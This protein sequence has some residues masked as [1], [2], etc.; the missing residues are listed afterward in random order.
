[1]LISELAEIPEPGSADAAA[2]PLA[3]TAMGLHSSA[4]DPAWA[5][6]VADVASLQG[7]AAQAHALAVFA[8]GA[9][10]RGDLDPATHALARA[11]ELL[12]TLVGDESVHDRVRIS[13]WLGFGASMLERY[14]DALGHFSRALPLAR[15]AE[16]SLW[17][18]R[19]LVGLSAAHCCLGRLGEA[20]AHAALAA[21]HATILGYDPLK[22]AAYAAQARAALLAGDREA[23]LHAAGK[24]RRLATSVRPLTWN[25]PRLLFAEA[26]LLEG[27]PRRCIELL[28]DIAEGPQ[29]L[30]APAIIR[31]EIYELLVRASLIEGHAQDALSWAEHA[32]AAVSSSGLTGSTGFAHLAHSQ[33]L[34]P[35]EP[36]TAATTARAAAEALNRAGR[37]VES[38][39]A[40][41]VAGRALA[42]A[43]QHEQASTEF[44][45]AASLFDVRGARRTRDEA[46]AHGA[47]LAPDDSTIAPASGLD[48]LSRRETQVA[49]QVIRGRTNREIAR[50]LS[51]SPRTVE[52]YL[53]RVFTKLNASCRAE[54]AGKLACLY[55]HPPHDAAHSMASHC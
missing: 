5:Q 22:E 11:T 53:A 50:A 1:M 48:L 52:T 38:A 27:H 13:V 30:A 24:A 34:L 19:I 17:A 41:V 4:R 46:L 14:Q 44:E 40:R 7:A 32:G 16:D 36:A 33:A 43:G 8:L 15:R 45:R 26:E 23:V 51:L 18:T 10:E 29:L 20:A 9:A 47:S 21:E 28:L 3:L 55:R 42:A 37:H 54:V 12:G 6:D 2:L 31:P 39:R 49:E 35:A 25:D